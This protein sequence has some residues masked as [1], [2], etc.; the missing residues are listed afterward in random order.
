MA[1]GIIEVGDAGLHYIDEGSGQTLVMI[2]GFPGFCYD[3]RRLVPALSRRF[4]I[5]RLDIKGIGHSRRRYYTP[6]EMRSEVLGREIIDALDRLG[7]DDYVLVGHDVGAIVAQIIAQETDLR[8]LILIN[9]PYRGMRGRWRDVC[10]DYW[11][12]FFHQTPF[13]ERM[14]MSHLEDYIRYFLD[15]WTVVK[16]PEDE[17]MEYIK[18]YND[19]LA[20]A[21]LVNW[22]RGFVR[23]FRWSNIGEVRSR[24]LILW[25]DGDPIFPY[26]WT[27]RLGEEFTNYE[28][29]RISN[30][31]HFPHI[32]QHEEVMNAILKFLGT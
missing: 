31:G 21:T 30:A 17:V 6:E 11:Y 20:V 10:H 5:V 16:F 15:G 22:Y 14:I 8:G 13:A 27:D 29:V 7:I 3:Y 18:A 2:H 9:P 26:Q 12:I 24:S 1:T 23:Y 32:E 28:L 4:R 19:P 25:S